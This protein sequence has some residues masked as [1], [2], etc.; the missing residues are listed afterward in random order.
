MS[1]SSHQS[2]KKNGSFSVSVEITDET[3]KQ[4]GP[5][6][7]STF[8]QKTYGRGAVVP[9][10]PLGNEQH[11]T[12]MNQNSNSICSLVILILYCT[13]TH[14]SGGI[15]IHNAVNIIDVYQR[16]SWYVCRLSGILEGCVFWVLY[17]LYHSHR[18]AKRRIKS[19]EKWHVEYL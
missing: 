4:K 9:W 2:V 7:L 10:V 18:D 11:W 3:N 19:L 12:A 15:K 13:V 8:L 5:F 16:V 6:I 14:T 17:I 1:S